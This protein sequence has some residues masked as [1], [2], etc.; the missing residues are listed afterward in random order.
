MN[1]KN[2]RESDDKYDRLLEK[3]VQCYNRNQMA[4]ISVHPL[5]ELFQKT[6]SLYVSFANTIHCSPYCDAVKTTSRGL[7]Y[8]WKNKYLLIK[9]AVQ[10]NE[11]YTGRCYLGVTE[12]VVPVFWKGEPQCILYVGNL[13]LE[14]DYAVAETWLNRAV[15]MTG[16]NA[17]LLKDVMASVKVIRMGDIGE[18]VELGETIASII[19]LCMEKR[20]TGT[21]K[22]PV[23]PIGYSGLH[24]IIEQIM[25]HVDKYYYNDLKLSRMADLYFVHPQYLSRLFSKEAKMHF[26]EYVN[27]VRVEHAKRLLLETNES[28]LNIALSVGYNNVTYFNTLFKKHTRMTPM[29]YRTTR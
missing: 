24:W 16:G 20:Q 13:M 2:S 3:T 15:R 9:K 12:V 7:R 22:A 28:I 26:T 4:R 19:S 18:Y 29:K 17:D 14:E 1:M 21:A 27:R 10:S 11:P 6:P 23:K 25:R 5:T 8:C